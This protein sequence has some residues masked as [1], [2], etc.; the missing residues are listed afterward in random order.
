MSKSEKKHKDGLPSH[1][2]L[3]WRVAE[4]PLGNHRRTNFS[5][6]D[7]LLSPV[8]VGGDNPGQRDANADFIV[9][10]CNSHHDLLAALKA[11]YVW[12]D[13]QAAA[14]GLPLDLSV[15]CCNAIGKAT[16]QE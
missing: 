5:L 15:Q 9:R 4:K 1:T 8:I 12:D 7:A 6:T 14:Q 16:K 11:V 2:P 13:N 3:P 10:A